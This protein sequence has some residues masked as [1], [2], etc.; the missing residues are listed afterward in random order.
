MITAVLPER[1]SIPI[2]QLLCF[3]FVSDDTSIFCLIATQLLERVAH[4]ER[5]TNLTTQQQAVV[6]QRVAS[7]AVSEGTGRKLGAKG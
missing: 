7:D 1:L 6:E 4:F 5:G 2:P 3:S